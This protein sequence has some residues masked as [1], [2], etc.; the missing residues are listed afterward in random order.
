MI[1]VCIT[2]SISVACIYG[3][4]DNIR[5]VQSLN[6]LSIIISKR[7]RNVIPRFSVL[8]ATVDWIATV[9]D[10]RVSKNNIDCTWTY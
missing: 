4:V 7:V 8:D 1:G 2:S 6:V 5:R 3:A 10:Y 9:L